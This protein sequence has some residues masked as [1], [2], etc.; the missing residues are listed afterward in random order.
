MV[1]LVSTYKSLLHL[2]HK[3]LLPAPELVLLI[4]A[5]VIA[6]GGGVVAAAVVWTNEARVAA[7]DVCQRHQ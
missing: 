1:V 3:Q 5:F 6:A 7:T 2:K 4:P